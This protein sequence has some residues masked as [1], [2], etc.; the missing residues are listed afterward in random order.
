[1]KKIAVIGLGYVGLP[2]AVVFGEKRA[3][4]CFDINQTRIDELNAGKDVTR[5]VS[6]DELAAASG[7]LFCTSADDLA[8]CQV[9][10]VTVPTPIDEFKRPDLTPLIK[11]SETVG[12]VL[13]PGDIVVYE[14]TVYPGATEEVCVPVLE[15]VSGLRFN[16]DFYAG[17]SPERINPGD[18]EHRITTIMKVTSGSTP[19]V[20]DEVDALYADVIQ[21][22]GRI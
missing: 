17:Y 13:K 1:M 22:R 3:V 5:E 8:Q 20:A 19:A 7:L 9:F 2:L 10:I 16:Q 15:R 6:A 21:V 11:A 4:V 18:K 12:R 14:S